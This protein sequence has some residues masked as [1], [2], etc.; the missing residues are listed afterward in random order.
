M[1]EFTKDERVKTF[2]DQVEAWY[3]TKA[4]S[5]LTVTPQGE[6]INYDS[7]IVSVNNGYV[8]FIAG[9]NAYTEIHVSDNPQDMTCLVL[10]DSF[11][12]AI[13]PFLVE[14]YGTII[15]ID[16]RFVEEN[17]YDKYAW[18]NFR[19]IIF[20]NNIEAANSYVWS[21]LYMGA[22]GQYMP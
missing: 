13:V 11:G 12:N 4:H 21:K 20:V 2:K 1:Y 17:I 3:P 10:K 9:D 14:H 7:S 19:D 5:M 16:P 22:V 6:T 18:L 8:T 15:V